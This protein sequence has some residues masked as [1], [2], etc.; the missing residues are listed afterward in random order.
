MIH[1]NIF[2][3]IMLM[4]VGVI[5][6]REDDV[7]SSDKEEI[8]DKNT[9]KREHHGS[10]NRDSSDVEVEPNNSPKIGTQW[11]KS[12]SLGISGDTLEPPKKHPHGKKDTII[13][14]DPSDP[15]KSGTHWKISN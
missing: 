3:I 4:G 7:L 15:P 9:A 10:S 1:K 13:V 6:C 12:D 5:S 11:K 8:F 2:I 14:P